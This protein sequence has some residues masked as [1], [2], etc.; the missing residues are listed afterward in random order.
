[1]ATKQKWNVMVRRGLNS[2]AVPCK[3][4]HDVVLEFDTEEEAQA[5]AKR[6]RENCS[7]FGLL[8]HY[9]AQKVQ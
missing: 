3:D 5:R 8:P 2:F 6:Y 1:M 7:P 9:F 4:V